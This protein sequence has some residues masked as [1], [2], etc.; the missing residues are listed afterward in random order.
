MFR[1]TQIVKNGLKLN[2]MPNKFESF[3][4][5][6]EPSQEEYVEKLQ[7]MLSQAALEM[8]ERLKTNFGEKTDLITNGCFLNMKAFTRETK[9]PFS[10]EMIKE[11]E[12]FVE[13]KEIEWSSAE[14]PRVQ[15]HYKESFI[16]KYGKRAFEEKYGSVSPEEMVRQEY[17]AEKLKSPGIMLEMA[18]TGL[19]YK[20]LTPDIMVV[21]SSA[22]DD[23]RNGIDNVMVNVKT[24]EV[25]CVFDELYDDIGGGKRAQDKMEKVKE[26][27]KKGGSSVKYGFTFEKDNDSGKNKVVKKT[28]KNVPT[29]YL[30]LSSNE[31]KKLMSDMNYNVAGAP[32]E[33]EEKIFAKLLTFLQ[34]QMGLL[35]KEQLPQTIYQKLQQLKQSSIFAKNEK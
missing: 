4:T 12:A 19:F 17:K 7:A 28:I 32:S 30:A 15:Q 9:G 8:N 34:E 22:F 11:D 14:N 24:G 29:F 26:K 1:P 10:S 21:R 18:I 20:M 2:N 27:A 13:Q 16:S 25:I 35:E 6:R 5:E 31:L 33:T 3:N 23:Y